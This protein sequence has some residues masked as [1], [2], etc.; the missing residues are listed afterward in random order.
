[1]RRLFTRRL[2]LLGGAAVLAVT[3][4]G[5]AA[6]TIGNAHAAIERGG[7]VSFMHA[8]QASVGR[9]SLERVGTRNARALA[10]STH[11]TRPTRSSERFLQGPEGSITRAGGG[12]ATSGGAV[13][14]LGV[15]LQ[16]RSAAG[17]GTSRPAGFTG[18]TGAE[19]AAA[20]SAYDLEPPDQALCSNGTDVVE[21]VNNAYAVYSTSGQQQLAPIALSA[22]FGIASESAGTFTSDPRCYYDASTNRWFV[23]ELS[24][25]K[26]FS[27]HTHSSKSYELIAVSTGADPTGSFTTFAIDST[28]QNGPGCPCFGDYPMIG[29]D[30]SGFYVTTNEFSIYKPNFNGVQLYAMSKQGLVAA[31]TG[32]PAPTVVHLGSLA[33]PFPA[34]AVGET[35]HLSPALT[36]ADGSYAT[37]SGGTEYFTMSDAFPVSS[38]LLAVY[39][40]TNTSSLSSPTPA[41]QLSSSVVTLGQYYQ[42][43]ETGLAVSQRAATSSSQT[44]LLDYIEQQTGSAGSAGVLQADFDAVEQT[45]YAAGHL[46]TELSSAASPTASIGTTSGQWFIL[47]PS[48]GPGGVSASLSSEGSVGVAGQSLLYPDVVVNGSGVGD[49]VFTLTGAKYFPS[50]AYVSFASSGPTGKI[51]VAGAGSGPEDGFTCYSYFVGANY[52]GCRWGDFSGGVAAGSAVWMATEY[53]PPASTRDF[54]TN[55]GTFIF[56]APAG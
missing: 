14:N 21:A 19:Q 34:E 11:R 54:Y 28:D 31:A 51:Q 5:L 42:F 38:D 12:A 27:A 26:Y 30:A 8:A 41:L 20:N 17:G 47:S 13:T 15:S 39:A 36:P 55:W 23:V 50:A 56:S 53:V 48:S 1:M 22:L 16:Q 10:A 6:T 52:G 4:V 25:P 7:R 43:P 18:I 33:S 40:L 24:I 49:M 9:L 45:T 3:T 46:F 29:A 2:R 35:Y 44:P 37:G 32:A